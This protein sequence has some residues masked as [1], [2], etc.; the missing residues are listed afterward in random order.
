MKIVAIIQARMGSSRLPGKMLMPLAG[1]PVIQQVYDRTTRIAGLD[2]VLVATTVAVKDDGLAAYCVAHNI[3]VM[4][5]SENDVLDRYYQVAQ[6]EKADVVMRITG[7][8]PLLDPIESAKVLRL[9]HETPGSDYASNVHP[10]FLPDG[11]D[12]EVVRVETL[13]KVWREIHEPAAR[14]H[15]TYFI[16]QHPERFHLTAVKGAENLSHHRWTLDNQE[17]YNLLAAIADELKQRGQFGYLREVLNVLRD[18]PELVKLNH[19]IQRNEG[20]KK[21]LEKQKTSER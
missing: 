7:D 14:E 19:H 9:F 11:L 4:R 16:H 17:D 15:V 12:T 13:A 1:V 8:C 20:L 18:R 3:P 21:S 2:G 10:P 6:A 5:G